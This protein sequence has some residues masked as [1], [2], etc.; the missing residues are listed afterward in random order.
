[1]AEIIPK[2]K[3]TGVQRWQADSFDRPKQAMSGHQVATSPARNTAPDIRTQGISLPTA[4]DIE[5]MH[6]EARQAGFQEGLEA[7]RSAG[8]RL[9]AEAARAQGQ[10]LGELLDNLQQALTGIDQAVAEQLLDLAIEVASQV[11]RGSLKTNREFLLPVIR[12]AIAALPLHHAHCQVRLNPEDAALI[13]PLLGDNLAQ[14][15]AQ[16]VDDSEISRGGCLIRA[17]TSE[18]DAS[19]ETRWKRVLE[20]IGTEPKA[21]LNP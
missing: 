4:E 19:I 12:E 11:V 7:G 8:E 2:E 3:L 10:R 21:W 20:A 13:R 17:G 18:V 9:A 5:R 14:S 15:G 16:I 6:E 1:M